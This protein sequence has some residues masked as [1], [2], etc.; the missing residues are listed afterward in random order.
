MLAADLTT[1]T[2]ERLT[3]AAQARL[4]AATGVLTRPAV[5]VIGLS[6][7]T[8][9]AAACLLGVALAVSVDTVVAVGAGVTTGTAVVRV[10]EE[11]DTVVI[12]ARRAG[13]TAAYVCT[14]FVLFGFICGDTT[15]FTARE[16]REAEA[17]RLVK[18]ML[19]GRGALDHDLIGLAL[20]G[21]SIA[22]LGSLDH[23]WFDRAPS[24][25]RHHATKHTLEHLTAGRGRAE[26]TRPRIKPTFFHDRISP[27]RR[28][29]EQPGGHG[30]W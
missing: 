23:H 30:K 2:V 13:E 24:D 7:D 11:A 15:E 9:I 26:R 12:A 27:R 1:A 17:T 19:A 6:V 10:G 20:A 4:A 8:L 25:E 28:G 22:D 14:A 18:D 5:V 29:T 3:F 21:P 16:L